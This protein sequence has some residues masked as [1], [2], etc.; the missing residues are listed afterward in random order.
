MS[1]VKK[2]RYPTD[3]VKLHAMVDR[4]ESEIADRQERLAEVRK[5]AKEADNAAI[6]SMAKVYNVNPDEFKQVM[7]YMRK[8]GV[9]GPDLDFIPDSTEENS[10]L[11]NSMP[12]ES[13]EEI[14]TEEM[15][16]E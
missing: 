12:E 4:L 13:E 15:D 3:R 16:D 9:P 10:P 11:G 6:V 14:E 1:E 8:H 2:R 7:E 5:L